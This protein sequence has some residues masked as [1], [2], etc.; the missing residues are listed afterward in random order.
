MTWLL[1]ICA[2]MAGGLTTDTNHPDWRWHTVQTDHFDIHYPTSRAGA[3]PVDG[4]PT[5]DRIVLIADDLWLRMG[6]VMD[7]FPGERIHVVVTDDSD[8]LTAWTW[9]YRD[10]VV[11]SAHPGSDLVRRR[12]RTDA[13]AEVFAHELAH[14]FTHKAAGAVAER[15]TL[16]TDWAT[17]GRGSW[18]SAGIA[19]TTAPNLPQWWSE[20]GAEYLASRVGVTWWSAG[21]AAGLR[22][23]VLDQR[24]LSWDELQVAQDKGDV[25][26]G[27]RAY[28]QGFAFFRWLELRY[29]SDLFAQMH[30][31]S[32]LRLRTGS[33]AVLYELT[34]VHGRELYQDHLDDL[35]AEVQV[36]AN[37][38]REQ[39]LVEGDE[40]WPWEM[41]WSSV[42]LRDQDLWSQLPLRDRERKRQA[43]GYGVLHPQPSEDGTWHADI[44][45]SMLRVRQVDVARWTALTDVTVD[46]YELYLQTKDEPNQDHWITATPGGDY[47]WVPG[48]HRLVFQSERH[49]HGMAS[50][51]QQSQLTLLDV[52]ALP[53]HPSKAQVRR[54]ATPIPN[55]FR[56]MSPAVSPNGRRL[57]VV[58]F[59][60]GQTSLRV[61]TLAGETLVTLSP[62]DAPV[63]LSRPSWSPDGR[64][65]VVAMHHGGLQ[66]LW[67]VSPDTSSW[68]QIVG[69]ANVPADPTW[70]ED[71]IWFT[72]EV[73][74]VRDVFSYGV[75]DQVVRRLTRGLGQAATPSA[76]PEGHL[77]YS[78]RT[79]NGWKAMGVRRE[80]FDL[81][82]VS[83]FAVSSPSSEATLLAHKIDPPARRERPYQAL[84][85][86]QRLS[87]S[88]ALRLDLNPDGQN[89][90]AGGWMIWRDAV[91][92]GSMTLNGYTGED[93]QVRG[94]LT[95]NVLGPEVML[96]GGWEDVRRTDRDTATEERFALAGTGVR[97]DQKLGRTAVYGFLNGG[98]WV[99]WH[100]NPQ[101]ESSLSRRQWSS[102]GNVGMRFGERSNRLD[103]VGQFGWWSA[104]LGEGAWVVRPPD[105]TEPLSAE[106][107]RV[108]C[109]YEGAKNVGKTQLEVR[110]S[111][112]WSDAKTPS[113]DLLRAGGDAPDSLRFGHIEGTAPMPGFAAGQVAGDY[114]AVG[115]L[116]W[117]IPLWTDL[118]QGGRSLYVDDLGIRTG[119]DAGN[120][121][122]VDQPVGHDL[123]LFDAVAELRVAAVLGG[124]SWNSV[125]RVARGFGDPRPLRSGDPWKV[126]SNPVQWV[127]GLGTGW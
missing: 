7:F 124:Q 65:L 121:W 38:R 24:L 21:R 119:V 75:E 6:D 115:G 3:H 95:V 79:G 26:D 99:Q 35:T 72:A 32:A 71:G 33:H 78:L 43:T 105:R 2:G 92:H 87:L 45:G 13:V 113:L 59:E 81:S 58:D 63:W 55:T 84:A 31:A 8:A 109:A 122:L 97:V 50:G 90:R 91:G 88:P 69:G 37:L 73:D 60:A 44:R 18:G 39:G 20:G 86:A 47:A 101:E 52:D 117:R 25:M 107:F 110:L 61:L 76:T 68:T 27:E 5:A 125:F 96:W 48:S 49:P 111:G 40:L 112:G 57:A 4:G 127:I 36:W 70:T 108:E 77:M 1:L 29:G 118:R 56:S 62:S 100:Q 54:A 106:Y 17:Q 126:Q 80:R 10:L 41:G 42:D 93:Q 16:G 85:S 89:P 22:A 103:A 114:L 19:L 74:G 67:R 98:R 94:A 12:S 30:R 23:S 51:H 34:G 28:Q 123:V 14:V 46:S 120:G 82:V 11:V 9:P 83:G 15:S 53:E 116:G 104:G 64:R 66:S 102:R